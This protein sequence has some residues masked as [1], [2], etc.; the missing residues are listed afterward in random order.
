[1]IR[2]LLA[3]DH[4]LVREA[5]RGTLAQLS[6]IEVAGE[7]GDGQTALALTRALRPD[8]VVL[9]IGLPDISGIEVANR[10][11]RCEPAPQVVALSA[12]CD[13]RFVTE[14]LCAGAMAY[15]TKSSAGT[16]LERAIRAVASGQ[17]YL[18]PEVANALVSEL[19]QRSEP[20]ASSRLA[21]R[22]REVLRMVAEG[23]RSAAIAQRLNIAVATVEVHRRNIMRKLG[24]NTVAELTKHAIREGLV[25]L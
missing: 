19:R 22:E 7:A 21:R 1:M 2:V 13:K 24:V 10:L 25:V 11:R 4:R 5:L 6:G 8:V 14:M 23:L 18:C 3:E 16:E 20:D 15:V 12:H 17:S 9:D